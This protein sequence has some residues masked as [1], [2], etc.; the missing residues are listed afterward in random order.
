MHGFCEEG[1]TIQQKIRV[2]L[3]QKYLTSLIFSWKR[4][5]TINRKGSILSYLRLNEKKSIISLIYSKGRFEHVWL[6][7]Q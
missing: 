2:A 1:G 7:W 4:K 5:I 6:V 3:P